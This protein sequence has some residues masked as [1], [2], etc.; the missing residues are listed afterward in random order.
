MK[1]DSCGKKE[2]EEV[3][4]PYCGGDGQGDEGETCPE[5]GG[6]GTVLECPECGHIT[7]M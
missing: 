7:G 1:C 2:M 3:I 4:C 5:C 6:W